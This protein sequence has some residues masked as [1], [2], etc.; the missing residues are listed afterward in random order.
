MLSGVILAEPTLS[1][2]SS[3]TRRQNATPGEVTIPNRPSQPVF[4]GEQGEHFPSEISF[5]R[6][7]RTVTI[8]LSVQDPHGYFIPSLRRENFVFY[9]DGVK[10]TNVTVEVEHAPV[11][12]AVLLEA[13]GRYQQLNAFLRNEIPLVTRPLLDALGL[14]DKVAVFSYTDRVE[15]L[16][17]FDQPL[18][19]LDSVIAQ[20]KAPV[21][22]EA[23][24]YDA[25]IDV[26]NRMKDV[27]GR[28]ALLLISTGLDTFSHATFDDVLRAA[29]QSATPVYCIGLDEDARILIGTTGPLSKIDWRRAEERLE[30]LARA[31]GG[32]AYLRE[33]AVDI[34]GIYDDIMEHLRVRYVITYVSSNPA[35][36]GPARTVKVALVN[37]NGS[38]YASSMRRAG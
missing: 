10:Q 31:S 33:S 13:G 29:Q 22:S 16:R 8:R 27:N 24:L 4:Q 25:L 36:G 38:P 21:F 34:A 5:D 20:I 3:L 7:T 9:E 32:R 14:E 2:Q 15:T 37:A 17:N 30:A 1:I 6:S 35:T 23:N 18:A 19:N 26:L 12:L 11:T 28:K